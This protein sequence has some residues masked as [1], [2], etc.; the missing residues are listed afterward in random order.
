MNI[1]INTDYD[2]LKTH[3]DEVLNKD[4]ELIEEN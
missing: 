4:K 2:N 1:T 3:F